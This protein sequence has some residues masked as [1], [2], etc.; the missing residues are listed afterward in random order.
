MSQERWQEL[1][2]NRT[3]RVLEHLI[4]DVHRREGYFGD[5][6]WHGWACTHCGSVCFGYRERIDHWGNCP[7]VALE[8][9]LAKKRADP[10]YQEQYLEG[11]NVIDNS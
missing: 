7:V 3:I 4:Y 8:S 9:E 11:E 2:E 1:L 6:R 10:E 5:L